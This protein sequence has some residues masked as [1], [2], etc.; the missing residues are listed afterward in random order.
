M[1]IRR[2]GTDYVLMLGCSLMMLLCSLDAW[3]LTVAWV[4]TDAW[5]LI[6]AWVLTDA[7]MLTDA[8]VPDAIGEFHV[9]VIVQSS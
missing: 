9:K 8:W 3:V 1:E 5:V 7:W 2:Q 6:D 4:F